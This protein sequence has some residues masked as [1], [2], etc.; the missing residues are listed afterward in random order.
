[1]AKIE[2]VI[3]GKRYMVSCDDGQEEH[4]GALAQYIDSKMSELDGGRGQV[5]EAQLLML[6]SLQLADEMASL[7]NELDDLRRSEKMSDRM[8]TQIDATADRIEALTAQI[9]RLSA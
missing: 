5:S 1:M 3:H 2:V 7:Y 9:T 8:S 4:L 6:T